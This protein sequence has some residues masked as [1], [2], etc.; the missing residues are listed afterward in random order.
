MFSAAI[1]IVGLTKI[2]DLQLAES[3]ATQGLQ[4]TTLYIFEVQ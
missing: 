4:Y 3:T 1:T 2:F